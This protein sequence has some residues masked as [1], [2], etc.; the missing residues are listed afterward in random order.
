[1]RGIDTIDGAPYGWPPTAGE[2]VSTWG[3]LLHIYINASKAPKESEASSHRSKY[4]I[5]RLP[6]RSTASLHLCLLE[7]KKANTR[8][9]QTRAGRNEGHGL[10]ID[11]PFYLLFITV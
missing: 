5:H 11:T 9:D 4:N 2:K 3:G 10:D 7:P 1:M 6:T 8:L